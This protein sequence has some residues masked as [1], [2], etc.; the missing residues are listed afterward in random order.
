MGLQK[1]VLTEKQNTIKLVFLTSYKCFSISKTTQ[2]M[3]QFFSSISVQECTDNK[4]ARKLPGSEKSR[5]QLTSRYHHSFI[6]SH[7]AAQPLLDHTFV[8]EP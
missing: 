6:S 5:L 4:H 3:I 7:P 8:K 2:I 1:R